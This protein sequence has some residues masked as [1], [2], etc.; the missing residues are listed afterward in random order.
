M[1]WGLNMGMTPDLL[2]AMIAETAP[3][4][5]RGTG[6]GFF[7]LSSGVAMLVA[8]VVGGFLGN[9]YGPDTTLLTGCGFCLVAPVGLMTHRQPGPTVGNRENTRCSGRAKNSYAG[10][11]D[12]RPCKPKGV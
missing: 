12:G 10:A 9:R 6:Y 2:A 4:D 7:N 5:L 3:A 1:V 8:R 11:L